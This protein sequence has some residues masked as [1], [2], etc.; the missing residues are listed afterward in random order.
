MK[1]LESIVDEIRKTQFAF[2][3]APEAELQAA[4]ENGIPYDLV[5]VYRFANGMLLG[6]GDYFSA[7]D[8]RAFRLRFPPIQELQTVQSYGYVHDDAPLY[9]LTADWWQ[10]IDYGDANWLAFDANDAHG[11]IL[12]AFHEE[13][14]YDQCHAIVAE[15]IPDLLERLLRFNGADWFGNDEWPVIGYV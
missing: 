1:S 8:D 7:P 12:D 11:R 14:G 10:I 9:D 15:S 5:S 2:S 4:I 13:V 6:E 3:P